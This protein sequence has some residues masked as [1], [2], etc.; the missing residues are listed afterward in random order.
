MTGLTLPDD[1]EQS[2][3]YPYA[4]ADEEFVAVRKRDDNGIVVAKFAGKKRYPKA[5]HDIDSLVCTFPG[6]RRSLDDLSVDQ[7]SADLS[8]EEKSILDLA[9]YPTGQR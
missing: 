3:S 7:G 4:T 6:S 2:H 9:G 1:S 8:D 5:L